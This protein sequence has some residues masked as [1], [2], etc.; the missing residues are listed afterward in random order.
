MRIKMVAAAVAALVV[1][2]PAMAKDF[3]VEYKDLDLSTA[4]GVKAL[5]RRIDSASREYC[6]ANAATT[7]SRVRGW[8]TA[9]CVASARALAREQ[10]AAV[11]ERQA[12]K[13]G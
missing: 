5:E 2:T 11:I 7:G 1:A 8:G 6:G 9:Q 4:K 12:G 10:L 13:G 3:V